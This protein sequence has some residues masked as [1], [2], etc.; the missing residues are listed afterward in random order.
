MTQTPIEEPWGEVSA[1]DSA[2]QHVEAQ[3][4]VESNEDHVIEQLD[5][6]YIDDDDR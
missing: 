1:G 4:A 3:P 6:D 2:E 5:E